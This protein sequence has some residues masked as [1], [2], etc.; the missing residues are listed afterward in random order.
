MGTYMH[1]LCRNLMAKMN[2]SQYNITKTH[3]EALQKHT[4]TLVSRQSAHREEATVKQRCIK[5]IFLTIARF[6]YKVFSSSD[7]EENPPHRITA[8]LFIK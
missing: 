8:S 7:V 5:Q 4:H 3:K 2:F 6:Q 1:T